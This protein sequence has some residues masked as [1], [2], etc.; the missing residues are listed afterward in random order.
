MISSDQTCTNAGRA[1]AGI[2]ARIFYEL[3]GI[4]QQ[5]PDAGLRFERFLVSG[6]SDRALL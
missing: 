1:R 5:S 2:E 3:S 4:L 6:E